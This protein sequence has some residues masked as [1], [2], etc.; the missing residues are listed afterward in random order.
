MDLKQWADKRSWELGC[1]VGYMSWFLGCHCG[2][3]KSGQCSCVWDGLGRHVPERSVLGQRG[4][5]QRK[6]S[7]GRSQGDTGIELRAVNEEEETPL[8]LNPVGVDRKCLWTKE[9]SREPYSAENQRERQKNACAM[10]G[11]V[12]AHLYSLTSSLPTQPFWP[13]LSFCH[14]SGFG[15]AVP[16]AWNTSPPNPNPRPIVPFISQFK[17]PFLREAFS[18]HPIWDNIP[19]LLFVL[20]ILYHFNYFHSSSHL[21]HCLDIFYYFAN[22]LWCLSPTENESIMKAGAFVMLFLFAR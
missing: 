13:C 3:N 15:F 9:C 16:S 5:R 18:D 11:L 8:H 10:K 2:W 1:Q 12:P 6:G 4:E 17:S 7:H 21:F 22:L 20:I 14:S 19:I